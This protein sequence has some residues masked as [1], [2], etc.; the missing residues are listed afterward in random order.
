MN[1]QEFAMLS[2]ALKTYYPKENLLPNDKAMEL[3]YEQLKDIPYRVAETGLKK[4]VALN[5]WSPSI[6]DI[7]EMATSISHGDIKEWSEAW[8]EVRRAMSK[9]GSYNSREALESM[10]PLTRKATQRIGFTNLCMSENEPTSRANF[11]MIYEAL[12]EREKKDAQISQ[13]LKQLIAEI[14]GNNLIES[15]E[16]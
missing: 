3:W 5:K 16:N 15:K 1:R 2:M 14:Q 8:E 13:P 6:A 9:Y 4:W 11:R 12:A 10:T 7:R